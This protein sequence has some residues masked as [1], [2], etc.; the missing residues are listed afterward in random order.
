[1][2]SGS[3]GRAVRSS[4]ARGS[5]LPAKKPQARGSLRWAYWGLLLLAL[6]LDRLDGGS[7]RVRVEVGAARV[8]RLEVGVEVVVQGDARR[9]V[10]ARDVG[11]RDAVQVL[12]QGAQAVA[13][14][15]DEDRAAGE[16]VRDDVVEPVRQHADD[17]VLE[18]LRL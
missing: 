15:G 8:D 12:D 13:V 5:P 9:D 17:D 3:P 14:G 18:A 4:D 16:E 2:G 10:Q 1:S 7:R 6:V 11:V